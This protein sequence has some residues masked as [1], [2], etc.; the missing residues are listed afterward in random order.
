VLQKHADAIAPG[1]T[2]AGWVGTEYADAA[3]V[4]APVPLQDLQQRRLARAVGPKDGDHLA[5]ADLQTHPAQCRGRAVALDEIAD[6]DRRH[7]SP[8]AH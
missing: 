4:A 1:R 8:P 7:A 5:G 2:G 6:F 3:A